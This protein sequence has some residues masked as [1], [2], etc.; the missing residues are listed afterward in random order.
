M[1]FLATPHHHEESKGRIDVAC[2]SCGNHQQEP[3]S[4]KSTYCRKCGGYIQLEKPAKA[5]GSHEQREHVLSGLHKLQD[6]LGVQRT[7]IARCF[8]CPGER[9]VPKA[10][11]STLCPKCGAYI[12]LQDYKIAGAHTRSIRT[13]GRLVIGAKGDLISRRAYCG[14]AEIEGS[15]RAKLICSGDVTIKRKGKIGGEIEARNI[16]IDR[17]C[18]V[19]VAYPM[20]ADVVEID[21]IIRVPSVSARRVVINRT[22]RLIGAVSAQGFVVEKGGYF[23]GDLTI[24]EADHATSLVGAVDAPQMPKTPQ[25]SDE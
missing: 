3:A 17:K 23:A 5:S 2:P 21:G 15:L 19:E 4:A 25:G 14:S 18:D 9:E 22:G 16:R 1:S 8:E 13:G 12:D 6:M 11:T 24:G 7:T 10:A 20:R